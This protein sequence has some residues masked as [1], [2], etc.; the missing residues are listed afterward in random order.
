MPAKAA[1]RSSQEDLAWYATCDQRD[2]ETQK[3]IKSKQ[4]E[5][6]GSE[7]GRLSYRTL[8]GR[9]TKVDISGW[10]IESSMKDSE[11]AEA[12]RALE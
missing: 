2:T 4:S 1:R 3:Q 12:E 9:N 5:G 11:V 10:C 8:E 7:S 6:S